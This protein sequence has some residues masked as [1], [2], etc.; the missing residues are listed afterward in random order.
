VSVFDPREIFGAYARERRAQPIAG[1][2]IEA[3]P[4]LSRATATDNTTDGFV[5]FANLPAGREEELILE[6]I[7][8]FDGLG[9][10]FEWKVYD[11]DTPPNLRSLLAKHGFACEEEEAFLV[12]PT[13][14]LHTP[15]PR[16]A[17][18]RI[19]KVTSERGLDDIMAVQHALHGGNS[20][21]FHERYSRVLRLAP[22]EASLFC[23][24]LDDQPAGTGW[25]DFPDGTFADLHGGSV[26]PAA[27]GRGIFAALLQ[28]RTLEARARGYPYLMADTTRMSRPIL[29]KKG[30]Q[31]VCFTY[32][33]KRK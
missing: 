8:H 5:Q 1:F 19:T 3:L 12:L 22:Q 6:Q 33:L 2:R 11:F 32:P 7:R 31:H 30:F 18:V 13:T 25:I 24:Y 26:L 4:Y 20:G 15:S 23:A 10:N 21:G 17:G 27:R 14:A 28:E 16:P 9:Q 29:L